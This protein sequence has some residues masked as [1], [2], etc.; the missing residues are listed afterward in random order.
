[1]SPLRIF[2][3]LVLGFA[4]MGSH[5]IELEGHFIAPSLQMEGKALILNGAAVRRFAIFKIEVA[6]LYLERRQSTLEA[7]AT[8]PGV[9]RL[10]LLMLRKVSAEDLR[11]KFMGDLRS[12]GTA[13]ELAEVDREIG[14][15]EAALR[16]VALQ[17]GD[18]VTM[19]W[20]PAAGMAIA[21]NGRALSDVPIR[22]ELLYRLVLRIF[23]GP[24]AARGPRERLLG[25]QP[26]S[27]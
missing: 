19:D 7:V 20:L 1:M 26:A 24:D 9:K 16:D 2:V 11:K 22:N 15:L 18:V 12:A 21:L 13:R 4:S 8:D 6:A 23:L 25:L 3:P 5:A 27:D 14:S 10:R 17:P